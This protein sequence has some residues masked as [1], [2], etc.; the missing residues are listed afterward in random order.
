MKKS[1]KTNAL[2]LALALLITLFIYSCSEDTT[3]STPTGPANNTINGKVNFIGSAPFT[4]GGYYF[5]AAYSTWFPTGPPA[6]GD[7]L[8]PVLNNGKYEASYQLAG[9]NDGQYVVTAAWIQLPYGPGSVYGLGIYGCDTPFTPI[10]IANPP[11]V[12]I[13]NNAGV[14]NIN[15]NSV[16]DTSASSRVYRF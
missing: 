11:R 2:F 13:S 5:I 8:V 3:T 7:T 16:F 14:E 9:V 12:T 4:A 6:A 15:F 10:C 1:L